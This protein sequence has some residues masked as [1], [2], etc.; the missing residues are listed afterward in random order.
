[1]SQNKNH[2][3]AKNQA[4]KQ[5]KEETKTE[6]LRTVEEIT[7]DYNKLCAE[8]GNYCVTVEVSRAQFFQKVNVL[9]AEM[10][11]TQKVMDAA[12]KE[13]EAK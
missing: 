9:T 4:E 3:F 12:K 11:L 7:S 1:M 10:K 6:Q 13:S 8:W 5:K 2:T